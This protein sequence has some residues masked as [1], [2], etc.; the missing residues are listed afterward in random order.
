MT[1]RGVAQNGGGH[2]PGMLTVDIGTR[3]FLSAICC[4]LHRILK[5]RSGFLASSS[6]TF[7][8]TFHTVLQIGDVNFLSCTLSLMESALTERGQSSGG[9]GQAPLHPGCVYSCFSLV[10]CWTGLPSF[11]FLCRYLIL[12]VPQMLTCCFLCDVQ[13]SPKVQDAASCGNHCF[14][15]YVFCKYLLQTVL[16][17]FSLTVSGEEWHK[18]VEVSFIM[19][20]VVLRMQ[21]PWNNIFLSLGGG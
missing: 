11:C 17:I 10:K 6:C 16:C 7:L 14:P 2:C 15:T 18:Y 12:S 8:R 4:S 13:I 3:T 19:C 21:S 9:W 5:M 20:C 1:P